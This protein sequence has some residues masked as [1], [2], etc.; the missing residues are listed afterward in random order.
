MIMGFV[1]IMT[2][3]VRPDI[4]TKKYEE[5]KHPVEQYQA[6]QVNDQWRIARIQDHAAWM[7]NHKMPGECATTT[8]A[9]KQLECSQLHDQ[10]EMQFSSAWQNKINKGWQP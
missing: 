7:L 1:G 9:I 5:L 10:I 4:V 3:I 6:N 2:A 8:S